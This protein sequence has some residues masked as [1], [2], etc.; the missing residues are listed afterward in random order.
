MKMKMKIQPFFDEY[1]KVRYK[2]MNTLVYTPM[3]RS[4]KF[5]CLFAFDFLFK[6]K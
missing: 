2:F 6:I 5:A 4:D 1:F 3:Y